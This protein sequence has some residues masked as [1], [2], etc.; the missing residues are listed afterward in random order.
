M[1][2]ETKDFIKDFSNKNNV[3]EEVKLMANAL[4]QLSKP[5]LEFVTKLLQGDKN[6]FACIFFVAPVEDRASNHRAG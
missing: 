2:D 3:S 5:Y 4:A 1:D 6:F